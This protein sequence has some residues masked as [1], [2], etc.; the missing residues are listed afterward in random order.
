LGA[1][2][3]DEEALA[4]LTEALARS[5]IVLDRVAQDPEHSLEIEL[6]FAQRALAPGF[7][8]LP[9]MLR[10]QSRPV[11]EAVGH[12]LAGLLTDRRSLLVASSDLSH[13]FPGTVARRLDEELLS[14]VRAFDPAA[15]LH[16]EDE[17]VGFACGK[18]AL[19]AVLWAAAGLGADRVEI[20]HYAHSGDVTGDHD[21]VVG[22]GA[23]VVYNS[24]LGLS[25]S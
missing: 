10:D 11:V 22:Y 13:F 3:V 9:I 7:R 18:G 6:P 15:V 12:A 8:L 17:G 24:K 14:R 5:G 23:A 20:L 21:S 2:E 1:V 25:A 19:A 4:R 16:A